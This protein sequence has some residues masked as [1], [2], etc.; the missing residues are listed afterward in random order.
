MVGPA[1]THIVMA[2]GGLQHGGE[3]AIGEGE[4]RGPEQ[5]GGART[6]TGPL[7]DLIHSHYE[8]PWPSSRGIGLHHGTAEVGKQYVVQCIQVS[9]T[10]PF[11]LCMYI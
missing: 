11:S 1:G 2:C 9:N 3:D 8:V 7:A 4:P 10:I 5:G 6:R